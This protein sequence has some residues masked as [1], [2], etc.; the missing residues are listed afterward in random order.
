MFTSLLRASAGILL[1]TFWYTAH[2]ENASFTTPHF[3]GSG[4]CALCHDGL[5]DTSGE[6]VSIVRDWG[7]SMM[8]NSTKDPFWKAKLASEIER[9]AHLAPLINDVCTKCHA[10]M[11][12]YEITAVQGEAVTV[13]GDDGILN[14][15]HPLYDAAANGVSCTVCHQIMDDATLGTLPSF[16][17]HYTINDNKQIYGQYRDILA[18]PMI[19]NTGYTPV[20]S[21]HV[22]DSALC[23]VC[24]NLKTPFVDAD[25]NVASTTPESEFPEQMPYTEWQHSEFDDAGSNPQSCQDCHMPKTTSKVSTRPGFL[26]TRDGFA[27]HHLVGA[28]TTM[29]TLLRDNAAALDVTSPDM[30]LAIDRARAML[31]SAASIQILSASVTNGILEARVK[32]QNESGH[33][34]PTSYPS[35]RMWIHFKVTDSANNVVFESGR[36]NADGLITGANADVD[37]TDYE[38]HYEQ[39]TSADQVQIYEPVVADTENNIT[40]TLL[41]SAYYIKDNRLTPRGF[42][43]FDV[44]DDVAVRGL[45]FDDPDFNLGS[46]EITYRFPVNV[47]GDLN[48]SVA[49]NYQTISYGFQQDLY[50]DDQLPQVHTFKS[51]YDAQSLKHEQIASAQTT[52]FSDGGTTDTDGDGVTD[53]AD[54]CVLVRNPAQRDT[55][56]DGYG[57]YCDPDF[58]NDLVVN[59]VDVAYLK[60]RFFTSDRHADLDGNRTVNAADLAILRSMYFGEPGPSGIV[61]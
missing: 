14:P 27:R 57:N 40:F 25:G 53:S 58:N 1:F 51:M 29:L 50:Q 44:P 10:P 37:R 5:T 20:F 6:D 60:D 52:V 36:I 19:N 39:I 21:A 38:P 41:R 61:P 13:L 35:R 9:N 43:K 32:V 47:A 54:N 16:S 7:P 59:A 15:A 4:N 46:D 2:A 24:H 3:S 26:N 17:G 45:A 18:Q 33:K 42:D 22:S 31:Q 12:N 23:S 11:A 30:D 48:V 34:A 8:A 55:D 49:L 56:R 28:N